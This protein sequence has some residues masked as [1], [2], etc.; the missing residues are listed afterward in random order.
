MDSVRA[1]LDILLLRIVGT[2]LISRDAADGALLRTVAEHLSAGSAGQ[3]GWWTALHAARLLLLAHRPEVLETGSCHLCL[4]PS[5]RQALP[6][7]NAAARVVPT[8]LLF[9]ERSH[10]LLLRV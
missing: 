2:T 7:A 3:R 4:S 5:R 9:V 1:E 10:V 8:Q 6:S